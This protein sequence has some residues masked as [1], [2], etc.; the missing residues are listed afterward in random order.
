[1]PAT[2]LSSTWVRF[3][4]A[5]VLLVS[6]GS[7][8]GAAEDGWTT[9]GAADDFAVWHRPI[10]DWYVA[11]DAGLDPNNAGR[12]VGKPGTGVLI[13]GSR[14]NSLVTKQTF[15]DVE[16]HLEFMVAKGANSGVIFHGNYEIQI[17]DSAHVKKPTGAHCGG[18]YP[19]AEASPTYHHIDEGS[20]PRVNAAKPPGQ[21]QTLDIIFQS[22]RF[23]EAGNKTAH[24]RF[25]RVVHNGLVI[26]ENVEVPYA[27]GPNW[28][29]RQF[30]RGPIILQG[31]YGLVAFR[32]IRVRPW[33]GK[34]DIL[35]L[36]PQ[37][38]AALFNG[39][40]LTGWRVSPK[41]RQFWSV[42]DGVLKSPGLLREWGACLSETAP[43]DGEL[44]ADGAVQPQVQRRH[45]AP[46]KLLLHAGGR[47]EGPGADRGGYPSC[48]VH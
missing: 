17:L 24:A 36:P 4:A 48:Q 35:N 2:A 46:G 31:D 9:L 42:E 28:D 14:T 15:Q 16:V 10:G 40:D 19:R 23:D 37:G 33:N 22:P 6:L 18:V 13:N 1:M 41:V 5:T 34:T 27:H 39:K 21:W 3:L 44:R 7:V 38:F 8:A 25:V 12:L 45:G 29:R 11:G 26:Q 20:P 43:G 47:E 32:N 30:P